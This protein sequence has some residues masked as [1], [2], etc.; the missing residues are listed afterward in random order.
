ME[1]TIYV[2]GIDQPWV[3]FLARKHKFDFGCKTSL[4]E[5]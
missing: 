4:L 1:F 2:I 5:N 3:V